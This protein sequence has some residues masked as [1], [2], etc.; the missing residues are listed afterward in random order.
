MCCLQRSLDDLIYEHERHARARLLRIQAKG[1]EARAALS[2]ATGV[3]QIER[4]T[5]QRAATDR[6]LKR[7]ALRGERTMCRVLTQRSRHF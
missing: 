5:L 1:R 2:A 6:L 3:A 7:C 4:L